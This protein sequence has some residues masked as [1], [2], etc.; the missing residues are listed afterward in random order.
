MNKM[1]KKLT[2]KE[3]RSIYTKVPRV[4][5]QLII[6]NEKRVLLTKRSIPP[7][8]GLWHFP[9]GGLLYRE[10]I[11]ET[12]SR[13]AKKELGIKVSL[14]KFLGYTEELNDGF[15]H[16]ISLVFECK[17]VG[18]QKP[19][20]LEQASAVQFFDKI[21]KNIAPENKKFLKIHLQK[22]LNSG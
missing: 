16:N 20:A 11:K 8:N 9:G 22:L 13:I 4:T 21:P 12:I 6:I 19:K 17:I 1:K 15:R 2:E 7:F 14:Q 10:K 5:V 18:K 3:F